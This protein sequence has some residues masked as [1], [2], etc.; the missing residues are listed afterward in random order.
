MTNKTLTPVQT[1]NAVQILSYA[2]PEKVVY[3]ELL[4]V[5]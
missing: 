3:F 2:H 1:V 5:V 4:N